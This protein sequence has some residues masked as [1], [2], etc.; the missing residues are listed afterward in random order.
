MEGGVRVKGLSSLRG[1]MLLSLAL[2]SPIKPATPQQYGA[3]NYR[4]AAINAER[5]GEERQEHINR[6]N[7]HIKGIKPCSLPHTL[8]L[9]HTH[10]LTPLSLSLHLSPF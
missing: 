2:S 3:I 1:C 10:T 5:R 8:A 9:S 4:H 7:G 6:T